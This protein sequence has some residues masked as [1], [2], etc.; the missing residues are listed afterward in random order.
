M[1][2]LCVMLT[3]AVPSDAQRYT[4]TELGEFSP[5]DVNEHKHVIGR[6][7]FRP[8]MWKD[9]VLM[10]MQD[11]GRG[12]HPRRWSERTGFSVG[13]I[14]HPLNGFEVAVQWD[15]SGALTLL[16]QH[17]EMGSVANGQNAQGVTSGNHGRYDTT[18]PR[19]PVSTAAKWDASGAMTL[20]ETQDG[21]TSGTAGIDG[22]GNVWGSYG[23]DP[24]YWNPQGV[25]TILPGRFGPFWTY[26]LFV[27]ERGGAV[28]AS[29]IRDPH[30]NIVPSPVR[31]TIA[32]GFSAMQ[33]LPDAT[34]CEPVDVNN[35]GISIG[36]CWMSLGGPPVPVMWE[37]GT[38]RPLSLDVPEGV[39]YLTVRGMNDQG[40]LV[41][42]GF[43]TEA[44]PDG[45]PISRIWGFL[46]S[47]VA[48]EPPNLALH[49]NQTTYRAGDTLRVGVTMKNPGPMRTVDVYFG[50][51]LPD[52]D[53]VLWLTSTMPL[54]AVAGSLRDSPAMF[55]PLFR[56]VTWPANLDVTHRDVIVRRYDGQETPGVYHFLIAWVQ[57]DSLA[58]GSLDNGDVLALAWQGLW[59]VPQ[60]VASR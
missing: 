26:P 29:P 19:G 42:A 4:V 27:S 57:P 41:G 13:S 46:F 51:I 31:A 44:G 36:N 14:Y 40:A 47:T 20:L 3:S 25:R 21:H 11:L 12:G 1:S 17:P 58:D 16:S 43:T 52:G 7:G 9:G 22:A 23:A 5:T 50:L 53:T 49:L 15:A 54:A 24:V 18:Y 39:M 6:V 56:G 30:N 59:V 8:A 38:V 2:A 35:A 32:Q 45:A 34:S 37:H 48:T 60:Q 10:L 55:T 33:M 28:G